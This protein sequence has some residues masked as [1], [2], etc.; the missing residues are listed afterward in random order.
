M[1]RLG[2]RSSAS[3]GAGRRQAAS[4]ARPASEQVAVTKEQALFGNPITACKVPLRAPRE[5][6]T[7]DQPEA[8]G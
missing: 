3:V 8:R 6:Q 2:T 5:S 7:K 1:L 4:M